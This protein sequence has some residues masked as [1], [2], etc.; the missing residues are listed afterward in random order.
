MA[1][2]RGG[3]CDNNMTRVTEKRIHTLI[4]LFPLLQT[5]PHFHSYGWGVAA[6]PVT[7]PRS[8]A[9]SRTA[10]T[11]S[12]PGRS[13]ARGWGH[14]LGGGTL[15]GTNKSREI[16]RSNQ[17]SAVVSLFVWWKHC[18]FF[19]PVELLAG[20]VCWVTQPLPIDT[21]GETLLYHCGGYSKKN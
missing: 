3:E 16:N 6:C 14:P 1:A 8:P 9:G 11:A 7:P 2:A 4:T 12:P 18:G 20:V 5:T 10:A 17:Q 21:A 13:G 19:A 15:P